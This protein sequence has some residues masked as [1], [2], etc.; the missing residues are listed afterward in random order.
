MSDH[1]AVVYTPAAR[2]A[3]QDFFEITTNNQQARLIE[4]KG[5]VV[6]LRIVFPNELEV[7]ELPAYIPIG[8]GRI[9]IKAFTAAGIRLEEENTLGDRIR[10][11]I[12]Y[13]DI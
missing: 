12:Y 4:T 13:R 8:K 5:Q 9:I 11:E 6:K 2:S 1:F 7:V 10:A 3:K